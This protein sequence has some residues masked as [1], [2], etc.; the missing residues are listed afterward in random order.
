MQEPKMQIYSGPELPQTTMVLSR[1]PG[2]YP[3]KFEGH[4]VPGIRL[5]V[6]LHMHIPKLLYYLSSPSSQFF[7]LSN[8]SFSLV[9]HW[10]LVELH[11][12]SSAH[13]VLVTFL[14]CH[15]VLHVFSQKQAT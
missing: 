11:L 7:Q 12:E 14:L 15:T 5:G 2:S 4:V 9:W 3:K 13:S 10:Y 8:S 1:L 6:S